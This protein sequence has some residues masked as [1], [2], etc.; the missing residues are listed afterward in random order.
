MEAGDRTWCL[1]YTGGRGRCPR[2]RARPG[3]LAGGLGCASQMGSAAPRRGLG[4]ASQRARLRLAEGSAAPRRGLAFGSQGARLRLAG[5]SA[6]RWGASLWRP[7]GR[8]CG[9]ARA[10]LAACGLRLALALAIPPIEPMGRRRAWYSRGSAVWREAGRVGRNGARKSDR[11]GPRNN[12]GGG[13]RAAPGSAFLHQRWFAAAA[14][15]AAIR[16]R[17]RTRRSARGAPRPGRPSR[18]GWSGPPS[19]GGSGSPPPRRS[20]RTCRPPRR[21]SRRRRCWCRWR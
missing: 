13:L 12:A 3:G 19:S 5:G 2:R 11:S 7:K 4:C 10:P 9:G 18:P 16:P 14:A 1:G 8:G 6:G 15:P 20:C 21:G 17:Y